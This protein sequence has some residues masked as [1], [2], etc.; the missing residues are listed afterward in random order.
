MDN[1]KENINF[2]LYIITNW[3]QLVISVAIFW[4]IHNFF[5]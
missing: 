2:R 4:F 5:K 1:I 3:I